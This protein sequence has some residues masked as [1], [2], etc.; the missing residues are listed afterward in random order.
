MAAFLTEAASGG[1]LHNE[2]PSGSV[3]HGLAA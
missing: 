1:S 3:R 2:N